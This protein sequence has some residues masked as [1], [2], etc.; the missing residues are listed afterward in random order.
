MRIGERF[1]AVAAAMSVYWTFERAESAIFA[2]QIALLERLNATPSMTVDEA[3][4]S[5]ASL[6]GQL[7]SRMVPPNSS[8]PFNSR[9][10]KITR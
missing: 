6:Q 3:K 2:S 5:A 1:V 8:T 4:L 9:S 7:P 10:L